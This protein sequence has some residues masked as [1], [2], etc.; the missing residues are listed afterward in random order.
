M[1]NP[2]LRTYG[3]INMRLRQTD[4]TQLRQAVTAIA[5]D[6]VAIILLACTA[7]VVDFCVSALLSK[8][9]CLQMQV[10]VRTVKEAATLIFGE[11]CRKAGYPFRSRLS[12]NL[13]KQ[14]A[15][16]A[17]QLWQVLA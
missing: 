2:I 3:I 17:E 11:F 4:I 12:E 5:L 16:D 10:Q 6:A 9:A 8:L 1:H 14:A 15:A 7:G 13:T